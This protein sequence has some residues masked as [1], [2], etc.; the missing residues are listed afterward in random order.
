MSARKII[1]LIAALLACGPESPRSAIDALAD[2]VRIVCTLE[3]GVC[4]GEGPVE[5]AIEHC[6][7][8]QAEDGRERALAMGND[9][10]HLYAEF[11]AC[12]ARWTCDDLL[13]FLDTPTAPCQDLRASLNE[14]C[15]GLSPIVA[16]QPEEL[17]ISGGL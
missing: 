7:E 10:L 17:E 11:Y 2:N 13:T 1:Y 3:R 16:D 14:E 12:A 9:C 5:D 6:V 15:P 4:Y 8:V